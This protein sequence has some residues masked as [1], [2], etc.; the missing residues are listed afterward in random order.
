MKGVVEML[1]SSELE[2]D[3]AEHFWRRRSHS[4]IFPSATALRVEKVI[5]LEN[6][7]PMWFY[8]YF[9]LQYI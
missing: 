7:N 1:W 9:P 6:L 8:F 2:L 4:Q 5:F 3:G